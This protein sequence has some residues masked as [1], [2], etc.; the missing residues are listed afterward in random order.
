MTEVWHLQVRT[1]ERILLDVP[2]VIRVHAQLLDGP[3]TI[4]R[5]HIPLVGEMAEGAL[6]YWPAGGAE[7]EIRLPPGLLRV[8]RGKITIL[9]SGPTS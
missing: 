3:I 8:E 7:R 9:T 6:R 5:G 4:L 2:A 1:P